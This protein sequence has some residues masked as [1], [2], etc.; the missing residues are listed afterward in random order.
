MSCWPRLLTLNLCSD[1]PWAKWSFPGNLNVIEVLAVL[2]WQTWNISAYSLRNCHRWTGWQPTPLTLIES[3]AKSSKNE[4]NFCI[5][6]KILA[7]NI[8]LHI[9]LRP[10][11]MVQKRSFTEKLSFSLT[12]L[13]NWED[14][15]S[16]WNGPWF[17]LYRGCQGAQS[18]TLHLIMEIF[19]PL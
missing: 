10:C 6:R 4:F 11:I 3:C 5:C 16:H 7:D 14:F 8:D 18:P 13:Q 12:R 9:I 17:L 2:L 15:L 1:R 19:Y